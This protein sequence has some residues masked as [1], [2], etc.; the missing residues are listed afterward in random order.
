MIVISQ[1]TTG[2]EGQS[3]SEIIEV[4]LHCYDK[5]Y[6]EELN[7]NVND[8]KRHKRRLF[9]ISENNKP[10]PSTVIL[11]SMLKTA[12]IQNHTVTNSKDYGKKL[13]NF[14]PSCLQSVKDEC[15][16]LFGWIL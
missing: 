14:C 10:Y 16:K 13:G 9:K 3:R 15:N 5:N 1:L 12:K 4:V 6:Q 2:I 11:Q 7:Q 8:G